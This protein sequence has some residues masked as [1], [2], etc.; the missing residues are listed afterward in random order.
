MKSLLTRI[1]S[2]LLTRLTTDVESNTERLAVTSL[3]TRAIESLIGRPL[4]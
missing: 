1:E 3:S 2:A 4:S